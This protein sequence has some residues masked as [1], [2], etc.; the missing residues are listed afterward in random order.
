VIDALDLA[1][2]DEGGEASKREMPDT[3][4]L[5]IL[6]KHEKT[7]LG[8]HGADNEITSDQ[9]RALDYYNGRMADV[10]HMEGGSSVVDGTVALV[11]DN[12]LASLLKPFVSSDETVRFAPRGPEDVE[13]A[14]QATEYVNY[15]FNVDNRGF[16]ILHNW[17]KDA[18]LS[19]LGVVKVY[20]EDKTRT[21]VTGEI[22]LID[23]VHAALVRS[24]PDYLGEE[25]G[26][27]KLGRIVEDGRV[28]VENIPPEE[29]R[30]GVGTRD[31]DG[32][33]YTAHVPT[34]ITRSDLMEMGFDPEIVAGLPAYSSSGSDNTL[35]LA[36]YDDENYHG[37]RL[38]SPHTSNDR[39]AVR[40]EY[41]RVDYDGDGVAELRRIVRVNN[42]ILLN[43]PADENPFAV[44]CPIPMPHK[45]FGHSIADRVV[46]EQRIGTVLWR[47]ALDNLYKTNNPRPIIG[48][49]AVLTDGSTAESLEDNAPGAAIMVRDIGQFKLADAVPFFAASVYPMMDLLDKK[50][51]ENTGISRAG[52]GLDAN[53]IK[54]SGQMTATEMSMIAQGKNSRTE[55]VARIF[56]ETGVKRLFQLILGLVTK[57]QQESRIVRL[58]NTFVPMDP[59][60][61]PEM[62]VA[63]SVGLG[64]GDKAEQ[65]QM[66]A[67]V[68][69]TMERL[70]AS[71]FASL[72]GKTEVYNAVK[73]LFTA[74]GVK[75]TDAVLADPEQQEDAPEGPSPEEMKLQAEMQLQMAKIQGEQELAKIR[76]ELQAAEAEAK[77][78]LDRDQAE[79]EAQLARDKAQ[80]EVELALEK[81]R[82]DAALKQQQ[83]EAN[84]SENRPGG[85][86]DK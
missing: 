32:A 73:R 14:E 21:E 51:E 19:K 2:L 40:D 1:A 22:E 76:L 62:D 48:E 71:P 83:S 20:W 77:R 3:E 52:Q 46:Q 35:R 33:L 23:E 55:M 65:V 38:D 43:E 86:L 57:Y 85:D 54:K 84:I 11:V 30:V 79:F 15:I 49:G 58:R 39:M 12:G 13:V 27:A 45:L 24:Q 70:A 41:V 69:D 61:W 26:I 82:I 80:F 10:P 44:L 72:I 53:A 18:L 36:R 7:A 56:A 42:T 29:F 67:T 59:R 68:L 50:T 28:K 63:I 25:G 34:N 78:Q 60:G 81:A 8:Y 5:A 4:L 17:F 74:A 37:L 31:I 64:I 75:D 6:S 9:E 66:A 47:Q 16:L